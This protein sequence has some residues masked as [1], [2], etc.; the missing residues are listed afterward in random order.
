MSFAPTIAV[1][2]ARLVA[3]REA[4]PGAQL[5]YDLKTADCEQLQFKSAVLSRAMHQA[6]F[7]ELLRSYRFGGAPNGRV[8]V[9]LLDQV[10]VGDKIAAC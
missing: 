4:G 5:V 7:V 10:P 8:G 6:V 1:G 9:M 2:L 3:K